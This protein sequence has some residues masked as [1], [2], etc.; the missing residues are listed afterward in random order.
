[1]PQTLERR[2]PRGWR[3]LQRQLGPL[4]EELQH[5]LVEGWGLRGP[6]PGLRDGDAELEPGGLVR[7]GG[8]GLD[9]DPALGGRGRAGGGLGVSAD[10]PTPCRKLSPDRSA[11][12]DHCQDD[13]WVGTRGTGKVLGGT[14]RV[15][16]RVGRGLVTPPKKIT[17]P[18]KVSGPI[19]HL[20]LGPGPPAK[21]NWAVPK[22][23]DMDRLTT[24]PKRSCLS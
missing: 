24:F 12:P 3:H 21:K 13:R 1:M 2:L 19:F 20:G 17:L 10:C 16:R 8:R 11:S 14:E 4:A 22:T 9:D 6:L 5:Q 18:H 7:H 23:I 15:S